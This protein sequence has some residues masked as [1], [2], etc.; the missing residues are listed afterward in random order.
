MKW[1]MWGV[2]T[3]AGRTLTARGSGAGS[4]LQ[5]QIA[6]GDRQEPSPGAAVPDSWVIRWTGQRLMARSRREWES[7]QLP[8]SAAELVLSRPA[9]GK[10]QGDSACFAGDAS[11]Q[12]E[13]TPPQGLGGAHRLAEPDA[14]RPACQVM[15]DDL[16]GQPGGVGGEAARGSAIGGLRPTPYLRSWVAFSISAWRR[17]SAS[18]SRVSPSRSVM[19]A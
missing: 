17:W 16:D 4:E 12:R 5:H 14:R 11:G 10:M 18:R 2:A 7:T 9:L 15:G 1:R 3:Y 19:K 8:Q 6:G 13:E